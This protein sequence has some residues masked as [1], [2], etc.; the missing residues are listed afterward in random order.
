MKR[1]RIAAWLKPD[2]MPQMS[3]DRPAQDLEWLTIFHAKGRSRWNGGGKGCSLRHPRCK[4]A[5]RPDH[6]SPKPLGVMEHYVGLFT[7]PDE[8]ICD[9]FA[10]SATTGVACIR[11]GRRFVG[12]EKDP[13]FFELAANRLRCTREQ[14]TMF[15]NAPTE[16]PKQTRLL[17][18]EWFRRQTQT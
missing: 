14:M 1:C 2:P 13:G 3:G 9:P 17:D 8:L 4:G 10:G 15:P 5:E 18:D 7:D 12:W 6:P 11:L 16:Q